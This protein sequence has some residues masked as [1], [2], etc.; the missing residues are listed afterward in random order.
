MQ[1]RFADVIHRETYINVFN[2]NAIRREGRATD[3]VLTLIIV[4]TALLVT[5]RQYHIEDYPPLDPSAPVTG[6]GVEEL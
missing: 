1:R 4:A 3:S 2:A 6:L 5:R